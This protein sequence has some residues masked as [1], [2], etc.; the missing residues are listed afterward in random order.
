MAQLDLADRSAATVSGDT[1]PKRKPHPEPLLHACELAG[2][3]PER[4]LYVGDAE[5]DI[6]AGRRAGMPTIAVTYG[7]LTAQDDPSRW[8]ADQIA[9]DT[10]ELAQFVLKAV[11]LAP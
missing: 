9:G 5:R 8:G 3:A 2:V 11:N 1:L 10:A 6:E 4:T 7:Y